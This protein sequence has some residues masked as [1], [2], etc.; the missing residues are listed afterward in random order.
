MSLIVTLAAVALISSTLAF[1]AYNWGK[2]HKLEADTLRKSLESQ[3][4][5]IM[6]HNEIVDKLHDLQE[7]QRHEFEEHKKPEVLHSRNAFNNSGMF[8]STDTSGENQHSD[9]TTPDTASH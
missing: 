7:S 6:Q 2:R 1:A 3:N 4:N 9:T 5:D 8:D